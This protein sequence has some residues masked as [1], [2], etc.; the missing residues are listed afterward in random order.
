MEITLEMFAFLRS[1]PPLKWD[2]LTSHLT[3]ASGGVLSRIGCPVPPTEHVCFHRVSQHEESYTF[4]PAGI[5]LLIL[6][7][8]VASVV[9]T[10][11]SGFWRS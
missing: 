8:S 2:T 1:T 7:K 9:P 10:P 11:T 4:Y 5:A 3:L 6:L